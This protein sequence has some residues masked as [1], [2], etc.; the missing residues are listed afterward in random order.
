MKMTPL[1]FSSSPPPSC[2]YVFPFH[3]ST[4]GQLRCDRRLEKSLLY[5]FTEFRRCYVGEHHGMPSAKETALKKK[6]EEIARIRGSATSLEDDQAMDTSESGTSGDSSTLARSILM[7]QQAARM[8]LMGRGSSR[9]ASNNM[10]VSGTQTTGAIYGATGRL[11]QSGTPIG[12]PGGGVKREKTKTT[13]QRK[14]EMYVRMFETMNIGD[15]TVV[16]NSLVNK[17]KNN[18]TYWCDD[19]EIIQDTLTVFYW[20]SNGYGSGQFMLSLESVQSL[21]IHH[22]PNHLRFLSQR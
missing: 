1:P 18:L 4:Q 2:L 7:N 15:H 21:L 16:I 12:I 13:A 20:L 5:F 22:G 11:L 3:S 9:M 10:S 14:R 19:H 8:G 6:K 17:V